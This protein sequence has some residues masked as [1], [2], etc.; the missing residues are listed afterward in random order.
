MRIFPIEQREMKR[1]WRAADP[2]PLASLDRQSQPPPRN[3]QAVLD[4]NETVYILFR[5]RQYGVPPVPY[6]EGARILDAYL[7]VNAIG[8]ELTLEN[9]PPYRDAIHELAGLLRRRLRSGGSPIRRLLFRVGFFNPLKDATD[10][11]VIELARFVS[12]RRTR[13]LGI[14]AVRPAPRT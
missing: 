7:R 6:H 12:G 11:D 14:E 4:L 1:R 2:R 5:G 3:L 10:A 13:S 9:L 8:P